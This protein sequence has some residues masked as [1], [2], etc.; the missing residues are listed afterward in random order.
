MNTRT[1]PDGFQCDQSS[2]MSQISLSAAEHH[3]DQLPAASATDP[4]LSLHLNSDKMHKL[5][6]QV[7]NDEIP[8]VR[9]CAQPDPPLA[10]PSSGF[11]VYESISIGTNEDSIE[12][13]QMSDQDRQDLVVDVDLQLSRLVGLKD[14]KEQFSRI[15]K[16]ITAWQKQGVNFERERFH[17]NF[18]GNPGTGKLQTLFPLEQHPNS[19]QVRQPS[20]VCTPSCFL[21]WE[22]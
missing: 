2:N 17:I 11:S 12:F 22:S 20:H 13:V 9:Q 21:G 16:T 1:I 19:P 5:S 4:G 14:V 3:L 15:K 7:F 6:T 10:R 18:L 8:K